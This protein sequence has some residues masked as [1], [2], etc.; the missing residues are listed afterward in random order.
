MS[1]SDRTRKILWGRSGNRCAIC[2]RPLV[3]EQTPDD[4]AAVVGDECHIAA[5]SPQGPRAGNAEG[6][7]DSEDNL[8]LL[9]RVDHKRVDDQPNYFTAQRLRALKLA[10][11]TWVH[12]ALSSQPPHSLPLRLRR[13]DHRPASLRLATGGAELL[14][15]ILGATAC[16]FD[17]DDLTTEGEV[18]VVSSLL[19]SLH[20]YGEI[21]DDLESGDRVKAR[22]ELGKLLD[23]VLEAGF[24]VY[25]GRIEHVLEGGV[26]PPAPWPI[27]TV[28]VKRAE[29][30]LIAAIE[31]EQEKQ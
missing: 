13:R 16:D 10:H 11:E 22:F 30:V 5:R 25:I 9:C 24:F 26:V 21:G 19:Q 31:G 12:T 18:E 23:A 8:I 17:S 29:N 27:A 20:D 7:L 3:A 15:L 6:K 14:A 4:P 28:R 2:R 1:I